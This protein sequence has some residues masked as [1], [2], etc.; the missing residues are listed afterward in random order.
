[1]ENNV[2]QVLAGQILN[3]F[4]QLVLQEDV[5]GV[6]SK[7]LQLCEEAEMKKTH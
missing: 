5:M 2:E 6:F 4:G 3:L 7:A 1:L